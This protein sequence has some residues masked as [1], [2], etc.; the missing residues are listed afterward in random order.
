[1]EVAHYVALRAHCNDLSRTF[2]VA[3]THAPTIYLMLGR[4]LDNLSLALER[5]CIEASHPNSRASWTPLTSN[6]IAESV[7]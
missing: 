5:L 3:I 1:M 2:F 4:S 6:A 7:G